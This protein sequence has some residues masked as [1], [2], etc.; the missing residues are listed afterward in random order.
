[1]S[2]TSVSHGA[3]ETN[4][5]PCTRRRLPQGCAGTMLASRACVRRQDQLLGDVRLDLS[6]HCVGINLKQTA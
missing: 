5:E 1:M 6:A 2:S 4:R 3:L